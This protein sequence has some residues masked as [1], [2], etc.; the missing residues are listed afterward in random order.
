LTGRGG[1]FI[2][3]LIQGAFIAPSTG[4]QQAV[5]CSSLIRLQ[6]EGV[7]HYRAIEPMPAWLPVTLSDI[8]FCIVRHL[9]LEEK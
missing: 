4:I 7:I 8:P 3:Q 5:I 6:S 9:V 1:G 2:V